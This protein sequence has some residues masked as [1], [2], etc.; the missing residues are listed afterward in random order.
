[1]FAGLSQRELRAIAAS[2]AAL[3]M[4]AGKVFPRCSGLIRPT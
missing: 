3:E 2:G 4:E 1:M